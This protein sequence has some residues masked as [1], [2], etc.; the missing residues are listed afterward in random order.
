MG[1]AVK[2][3]KALASV[4][5][6]D[7]FRESRLVQRACIEN[8]DREPAGRA[9]RR[10]NR[11][12]APIGQRRNSMIH[13]ILNQWLQEQRRNHRI[14]HRRIRIELHL[15]PVGKAN[16]LDLEVEAD[17]FQFAFEGGFRGAIAVR[18]SRI[19]S[20]R[21]AI[22]ETASDPRWERINEAIE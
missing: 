11:D 19:R 2:L 15:E 13:R 1:V 9:F 20:P 16:A 17:Q 6:A 4:S 3:L 7:T 12:G 21:R 8:F 14:Q 10:S 22:I 5:Q 18:V